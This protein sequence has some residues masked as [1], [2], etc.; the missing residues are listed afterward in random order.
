METVMGGVGWSWVDDRQTCL[1]P[2]PLL[3]SFLCLPSMPMPACLPCCFFFFSCTR[4]CFLGGTPC[5]SNVTP[6]LHFT[7]AF[8]AAPFLPYTRRWNPTRRRGREERR[9]RGEEGSFLRRKRRRHGKLPLPGT[10]AFSMTKQVAS[11]LS[12][13]IPSLAC[14]FSPS[15]TDSFI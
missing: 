9:E 7:H 6:L 1:P 15:E 3:G 2:S 8:Y 14:I 5:W 13:T 12:A 4:S 11:S 10:S